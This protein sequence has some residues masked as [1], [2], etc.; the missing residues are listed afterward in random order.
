M[1]WVNRHV[2]IEKVKNT[3]VV[4]CYNTMHPHHVFMTKR[5]VHV[6]KSYHVYKSIQ[7]HR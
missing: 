7:A 2:P 4:G 5:T 1:W 6:P 3:S